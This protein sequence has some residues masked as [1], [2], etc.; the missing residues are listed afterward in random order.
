MVP[1]FSVG[2]RLTSSS[3][4]KKDLEVER[5]CTKQQCSKRNIV[6]TNNAIKQQKEKITDV[7]IMEGL[8]LS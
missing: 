1:A 5:H 6:T 2:L 3:K 8:T 7:T 4:G